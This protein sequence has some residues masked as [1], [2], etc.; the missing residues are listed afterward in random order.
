MTV[1]RAPASTILDC[2]LCRRDGTNEAGSRARKFEKYQAVDPF[3]WVLLLIL[4]VLH[5]LHILQ[6]HKFQDIRCPGSCR[7]FSIHRRSLDRLGFGRGRS[8]LQC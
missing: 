1:A 2:L 7:S 3:A 6:H 4:K 8:L 5:D